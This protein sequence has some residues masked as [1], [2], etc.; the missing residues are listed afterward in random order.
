MQGCAR[1][2]TLPDKLPQKG[3]LY[4]SPPIA[5][6]AAD[7]KR[8][9]DEMGLDL[10]ESFPNIFESQIDLNQLI[11]LCNN[12]LG[13][14]SALELEDTK[15]LLIGE[16][17]RIDIRSLAKME[18][19][20]T[21]LAKVQG[22]WLVDV[23]A[24]EALTVWFQPIVH[25][26][27]PKQL[28]AYE[29]LSRGNSKE[30]HLIMPEKMF[31]TARS[32]DL[33]FHLDRLCR[34]SAIRAAHTHNLITNVFINFNP[35]AIYDPE[36]C[37]VSTLQI[38]DELNIDTE[39]IVFEVVETDR[40]ADIPHLASILDFYRKNGFRIAMDDMGAGYS[41][42]NL[43]LKLKPEFIK[44]DKEL[45][46]NVRDDPYKAII[47]SNMIR[48]AK[49]LG[50]HVIAE[51]VEKPSEWQW[52]KEKG[53]DFVQGNFFSEP[54]AKPKHGEVSELSSPPG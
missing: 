21:L 43:L 3:R 46:R 38:I 40:I 7:L 10:T 53:A 27:N 23:L 9:F 2:E 35:N 17:D 20:K 30:G 33:L 31:Q 26:K 52:L 28:Y 51:G 18:S 11:T 48:L 45:V 4:I 42:L 41:S 6:F 19:L 29:C 25:T 8:Y 1:C 16:D 13:I 37:L 36:Y 44:I 12:Y 22:D 32:A 34:I 15:C 14:V 5:P 49:D 54:T 50:I 24:S 47:T 39:R